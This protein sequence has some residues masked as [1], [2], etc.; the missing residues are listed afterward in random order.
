MRPVP[1][2]VLGLLAAAVVLAV[3]GAAMGGLFAATLA[4]EAYVLACAFAPPTGRPR[5]DDDDGG[6]GGPP[7][8]GPSGPAGPLEDW[9]V[10][11]H[12]P[13]QAPG[14]VTIT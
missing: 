9:P 6:L 14:L 2:C 12:E 8:G 7:D 5:E 4:I 11:D 3:S 10:L 13:D 1:P